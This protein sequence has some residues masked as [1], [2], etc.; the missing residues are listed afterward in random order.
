MA[1]KRILIGDLE[2]PSREL[3]P[4]GPVLSNTPPR[5]QG[6]TISQGIFLVME[7]RSMVADNRC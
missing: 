4:P 2:L 7:K 3:D 5:V 6:V 1:S